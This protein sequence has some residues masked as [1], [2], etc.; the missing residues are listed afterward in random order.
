M[1][2]SAPPLAMLKDDP[3]LSA[4]SSLQHEQLEG[5]FERLLETNRSFNLTALRDRDEAWQRHIVE[6]LRLVPLLED[7]KTLLDVGSGG[8]LPGIVLAIA[9][10]NVSVTLLEATAKKAHF[11][12]ETAR[13]LRLQNLSVVCERAE[14]AAALGSTLRES[15]DLVSARAVAPLRTLL[16]LTIPFLK[17]QGRLLAVKGQRAEEEVKEAARASR[18][19]HCTLEER[20][21]Q[22]S[23]TILLFRKQ[24]ATPSKYPRRSGEPKQHPL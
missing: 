13:L 1:T 11:L 2:S 24:E 5:F 18:L 4:L 9:K 20:H 17:I 19:L 23:A 16:E 22:P 14:E 3:A 7:P 10:P 21:R 8:G 6:S 15:F 12:E